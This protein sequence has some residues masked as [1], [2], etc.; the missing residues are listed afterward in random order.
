MRRRHTVGKLAEK[1]AQDV[2]MDQRDFPGKAEDAY[3]INEEDARRR[4]DNYKKMA[5]D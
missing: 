2:R 5:A 1:A 4:L 3:R